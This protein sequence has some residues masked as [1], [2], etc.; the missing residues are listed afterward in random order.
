MS[1]RLEL[2]LSQN[3]ANS[4]KLLEIFAEEG[5]TAREMMEMEMETITNDVGMISSIKGRGDDIWRNYV[6]FARQSLERAPQYRP[7]V[8]K[9]LKDWA[10]GLN[11]NLKVIGS[12]AAA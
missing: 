5:T 6:Q 9:L 12:D 10:A 8:E 3:D 7:D 11:K 4:S 2:I 1:K